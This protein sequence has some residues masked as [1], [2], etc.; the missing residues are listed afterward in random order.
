MQRHWQKLS[1]PRGITQCKSV[2]KEQP[3]HQNPNVNHLRNCVQHG[4]STNAHNNLVKTLKEMGIKL[5]ECNS[6]K[7]CL[8]D[9]QNIESRFEKLEK[10]LEDSQSKDEIIKDLKV[11]NFFK[12]EKRSKT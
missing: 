3:L 11:T 12:V 10:Q 8:E 4:V 2:C 6:Q 7:K 9:T 1:I 5:G